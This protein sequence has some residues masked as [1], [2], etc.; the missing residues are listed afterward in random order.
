MPKWKVPDVKNSK[1][2]RA[3]IWG[4][5]GW[6][7]VNKPLVI[8]PI[9]LLI[10]GTNGTAWYKAAFND[11][12][13]LKPVGMIEQSTI[14]P[15]VFAGEQKAIPDTNWICWKI[16]GRYAIYAEFKPTAAKFELE[17]PSLEKIEYYRR[18]K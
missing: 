16:K 11:T 9:F 7:F 1:E 2:A 5:F 4:G 13:T 8:W 18:I 6:F 14:I 12:V 15:Q 3:L 10:L 17:L